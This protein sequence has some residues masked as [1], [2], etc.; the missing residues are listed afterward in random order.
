MSLTLAE[1][2]VKVGIDRASLNAGLDE[3]RNTITTKMKSAEE[4]SKMLLGGLSVAGAG[5]VA[6][7]VKS[8]QMA[9]NV[10]TAQTA[11]TTMLG[12]AEKAA[13]LMKDLQAFGA[14][15][16]FEF[17]EIQ[18]A[19]KS[20]LAF[21][22]GA[23]EMKTKLREIG[24]VSSAVGAP[25]GEIAEIYGKAKTAGRLFAEDINQLT[26]RG[27]PIIQELAKQFNVSEGEV[28][29]LVESGKVG[30]PELEKAFS[31]MTGEGGKFH[32]M[33]KA[34]S[35]TLPGMWSN[36]MDNIGQSATVFGQ[37]LIKNFDLKDKLQGLID[38]LGKIS[39]LLSEKGLKGALAELFPP[40]T[41]ATIVIIGG[42]ILG[43]LVPAIYALAAGFWAAMVPLLPF[44]AAGAAIAALAFLIYQG[45]EPLKN[46]FSNLWEGISSKVTGIWN[47]IKSTAEGVW[48][49][50][51]D[52]FKKWGDELLLLAIGPAG[53]AVLLV[54]KIVENWDK[55]KETTSKIWEAITSFLSEKWQAVASTFSNI[56]NTIRSFFTGLWN[57]ISSQV[58][59]IWGT[60][61][62][63]I[64]S[65][66]NS[67]SSTISNIGSTV[68]G[69][70]TNLASSAYQW[71]SNLIS[72]FLRGFKSKIASIKSAAR[73]V[74]SS[75][76]RVIGFRSPAKEGP[77]AD[78]D[79]WGP[80]L[81]TMFAQGLRQGVP[82]IENTVLGVSNVLS[83]LGVMP[84]TSVA[85][86]AAAGNTLISGNTF[87]IR[88]EAD[89]DKVAEKLAKK[90]RDYNRGR[91]VKS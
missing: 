35:A 55:I 59:S 73:E 17:P 47:S 14:E 34:Q 68:R 56:G 11:F 24:D 88:E 13:A 82:M 49:S 42:A 37:E 23:D 36:L 46:F 66:F 45:W 18:A 89:I 16:P 3:A 87:Y 41:Q 69:I 83:L 81:I 71:G 6:F 60:I 38:G 27:I 80:N 8:L 30:F 79:K 22:I 53:W 90:Q 50:I 40:E 39:T 67:I 78:A 51:K 12:S 7:G 48:N 21:G 63:T 74:A 2:M 62:N 32:D 44:I 31:S 75:V 54:T 43:A 84:D 70:F 1:V 20:L 61:H 33:M 77:G 72:E 5:L 57:G 65:K 76:S 64:S 15:T 28:K 91:G 4:S 86:A 58:S 29:G 10:E 52:F 25:I 19:A 85:G 26:G 9:G